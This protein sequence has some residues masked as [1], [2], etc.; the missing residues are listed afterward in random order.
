MIKL[1]NH[2]YMQC[3]CPHDWLGVQSPSQT[4]IWWCA[5]FY[6]IITIHA[7]SRSVVWSNMLKHLVIV[8][9][10]IGVVLDQGVGWMN[11][12]KITSQF[13]DWTIFYMYLIYTRLGKSWVHLHMDTV[14]AIK[15]SDG[16]VL[17]SSFSVQIMSGID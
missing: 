11:Y 16:S 14:K 7:A 8:N 1:F 2:F 5:Q 13:F 3:S 10:I 9:G 12:I 4:R 15:R 6:L 17:G